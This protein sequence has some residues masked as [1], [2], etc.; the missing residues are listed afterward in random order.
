MARTPVESLERWRQEVYEAAPERT[1]ETRSTISGIENE[2]LYTPDNVDVDYTARPRSSRR[3]SVHARRLSVDVPRPPLDDAAVRGL[4]VGGGDE[5]PLPLPPRARSDRPLHRLRHADADGLRLG[6]RPLAR[7]GRPRGRRS[8]LDRR[9]AHALRRDPARRRLDVDDDQLAVRDPARVLRLRGRGAGRRARRSARDGADRHPQ[10]VHR[11]EGVH[12]PA[13]AVDAARDGHGG[14]L[15]ARDAAGGIRSRSPAT[16]SARPDRRPR[17]SSR[18]RSR[19]ASP[20]STAR[21]SEGSASTSSLR[22]CRSS[23]TPIRTSSRRS[24]STARPGGSGR[25]SCASAT[26]RRTS[27]AC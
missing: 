10:G 18:S 8:R 6:P 15:R 23:S 19:T 2:P 3:L 1:G 5:R 7:R 20:T 11:A 25:A 9:H 21:S 4:R 12:L 17:R 24:R 27:A 16:T 14:V 22:G 13:R 26:A